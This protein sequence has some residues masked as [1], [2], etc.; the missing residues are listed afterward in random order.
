MK[1]YE[2][3]KIIVALSGGVDSAV[4]AALLKKQGFD[5]F[6]VHFWL[7]GKTWKLSFQVEKITKKLGIT[8]KV[9]DARKEFKKRII[10][11]FIE[12]YKKG[13]TPNPCVV[14]NKEI[15][16]QLLFD[17]MKKLDADYVSTGHY[18]LVKVRPFPSPTFCWGIP[19][20][21]TLCEARDKIKDQSYF[22]YRLAQKDLAKII[23]PLG[24]YKKTE[25]KEI[26]KKMKI[27]VPEKEESQDICFLQNKDINSF[28]RKYIKPEPGNIVDETGKI[29]GKHEG[30]AAY[31]LGQ[32][33]GIKIGGTGPYFVV[34][35]NK[36]KNK[37]IVTNDP[38]EF[39]A[40]KFLISKV[41]WI[42]PEIKFPLRA[43]VQIRYHAP[44]VSAI[45][46]PQEKKTYLVELAKPLRAITPGQSAVFYKGDEVLGGGI[47]S[48]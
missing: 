4:A 35:K 30:L 18:A 33:K 23:F 24:E 25:V 15:K 41:S 43:K 6:G 5:V 46:K 32:R 31:T 47:I 21:R 10:G 19:Q 48:S 42:S 2:S 22:L 14:C 3:K 11:Y 1:L 12:A 45:I 16:F 40:R 38:K 13:L 7:F 34:G 26:A 39:L 29:F 28:L 8:L 36:R 44:K 27:P 20:G 37:L 9:V 17:L